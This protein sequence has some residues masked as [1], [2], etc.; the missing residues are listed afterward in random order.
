MKLMKW[1]VKNMKTVFEELKSLTEPQ[2]R[3]LACQR[4]IKKWRTAPVEKLI[5]IMAR[6]K[7]IMEP[8]KV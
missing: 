2:I 4:D 6:M 3:A 7:N 8:V 1:E 5:E